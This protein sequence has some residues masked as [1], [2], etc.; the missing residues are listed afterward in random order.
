MYTHTRSSTSEGRRGYNQAFIDS[1]DVIL[2]HSAPRCT[3]YTSS[4]NVWFLNNDDDTLGLKWKR[5]D[6]EKPETDTEIENDSEW[7]ALSCLT[8]R[9]GW[10]PE[11]RKGLDEEVTTR[12]PV[13]YTTVPPWVSVGGCWGIDDNTVQGSRDEFFRFGTNH[14]LDFVPGFLSR[15]LR[16]PC[17][18]AITIL[19]SDTY[20]N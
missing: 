8:A 10:V 20:I 16:H 6:S 15:M 4:D 7:G 3:H 2:W 11:R 9:K 12:G 17:V 19:P 13:L 5:V 14:C 18:F 1:K